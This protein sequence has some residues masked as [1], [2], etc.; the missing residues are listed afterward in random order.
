[1]RHFICNQKGAG[2]ILTRLNKR[3]H[4]HIADNVQVAMPASVITGVSGSNSVCQH[5]RK[6]KKPFQSF[7]SMAD[8]FSIIQLQTKSNLMVHISG[9]PV[10]CQLTTKHSHQ[11][12]QHETPSSIYASPKIG[13]PVLQ[14]QTLTWLLEFMSAILCQVSVNSACPGKQW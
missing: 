14:G 9:S 6:F 8:S 7:Q 13:Y 10:Y 1:M 11:R 3:P 5:T 4:A 12:A 2:G